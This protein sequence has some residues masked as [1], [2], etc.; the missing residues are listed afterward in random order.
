MNTNTTIILQR[1]EQAG[2][3]VEKR[4]QVV[5]VHFTEFEEVLTCFGACFD[6]EINDDV[7]ERGLQ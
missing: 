5:V 4:V 1:T 2:P 3:T 7:S 6:L